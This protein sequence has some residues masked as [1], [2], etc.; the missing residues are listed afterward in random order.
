M[1]DTDSTKPASFFSLSKQP[2]R[3]PHVV[4]PGTHTLGMWLFL[5]A[6][7]VLFIGGMLAYIIVRVSGTFERTNPLTGDILPATAPPLHTLPVPLVL[8]LSTAAILISSYTI[9]RA[10]DNVIHERQ[11]RFRQALIA[12][13]LLAVPF[14]LAQ[15][16]G[17]ATMLGRAAEGGTA[18]QYA[19]F[20]LIVIHALHVV[21]GLVPLIA[22]TR[23][24][25]KGRYDH[26]YHSPVKS[27]AMYWHFLDAVW[28]L[29]FA[30]F[31]VLG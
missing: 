13:L 23:A 11:D 12:T 26:E 8:W 21:G 17:L 15:G 14:F 31:L 22:V 29:M 27:L 9:H 4:P 16:A 18:L 1:S 24:A 25:H 10:L 19:V 30:T 3:P 2:A 5:A 28:L 6:L 20:I 7:A